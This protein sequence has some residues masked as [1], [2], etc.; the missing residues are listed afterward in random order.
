[1]Y[2]GNN[3]RA[4]KYID[5]SNTLYISYHGASTYNEYLQ[6]RGMKFNNNSIKNR[7]NKLVDHKFEQYP[8]VA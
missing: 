7:G 4:N 5:N 2:K 8:N 1:M 3:N 6:K